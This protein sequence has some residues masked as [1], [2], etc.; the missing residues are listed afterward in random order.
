M[1]PARHIAFGYSTQ[2]NLKCGHCVAADDGF[3]PVK[4]TPDKAMAMID[5]MAEAR[6]TGISFTAGEPFLFPDEIG[7]LIHRCRSHGIYTR[8]VTNGFWAKTGRQSDLLISELKE[9]GLSQLRISSSRWH[10]KNVPVK[11]LLNAAA[12]CQKLGLDYFISF[13]TDFSGQDED[14]EQFFRD[15]RLKF[16]PEPLIYAG[17]AETLPRTEIHTDYRPN[18]CSLNPYLSPDLEMFACCD[19]GTSFNRTGFFRLGNCRDKTIDQLFRKKENHR[20][21][22]LI[23]TMGLSAMASHI[24]F[25]ASRIVTYR[26]C[27]LCETLFNSP[28][29]LGILNKAVKS[30]LPDWI[31]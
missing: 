24:G 26:K 20:L 22:H 12:S 7:A 18:R 11:N 1:H 27:D 13:I 21:Y 16:F 4:M 14:L 5:E 6:V 29:N 19:A 28:E 15:H 31:R 25:A 30:G 2:C 10:Q 23:R 3:K 17:R 8:M 9:R